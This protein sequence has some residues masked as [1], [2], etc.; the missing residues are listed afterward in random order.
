MAHL[1]KSKVKT[2]EEKAILAEIQNVRGAPFSEIWL[3]MLHHPALTKAVSSAGKILRFQGT[4]PGN[5]REAVIL[6]VAGATRSSY[7]WA[8]HI[9]MAVKEGVQEEILSFLKKHRPFADFPEPYCDV[10]E[11]AQMCLEKRSLPSSLQDRLIEQ[12]GKKGLVELVLLAGFY[13]MIAAFLNA[14]DIEPV[15]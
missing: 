13:Q 10:I 2:D 5:I 6:Y 8:A 1:E 15:E 14:F 7:E 12:Y 11:A 9:E 4:L 3:T